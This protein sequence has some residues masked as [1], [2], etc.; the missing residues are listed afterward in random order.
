MA[1][2]AIQLN[3]KLAQVRVPA[4]MH[5]EASWQAG[6]WKCVMR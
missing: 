4:R 3:T 6:M 1:T 5:L 2:I